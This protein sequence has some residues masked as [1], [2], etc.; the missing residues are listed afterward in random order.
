VNPEPEALPAPP[1][2]VEKG[3]RQ[4]RWF[5]F[6]F[7]ALLAGGL[8][9]YARARS[10][11]EMVV[12]V[13]LSGA[14]PGDVVETDVIVYRDGHSLARVDDRHG[15]QGAPPTI[16]VPVRARPGTATVEVTLVRAGGASRRT[17]LPVEL[18][19]EGPARLQVR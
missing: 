5:R 19:T 15:P 3:P 9:L 2:A 14:L 6:G 1:A 18:T 4:A 12:E 16:R 11:R 8:V 13:D 17:A 10:P 7:L